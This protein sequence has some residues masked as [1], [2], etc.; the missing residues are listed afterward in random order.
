[1][2]S[3]YVGVRGIS[4][5]CTILQRGQGESTVTTPKLSIRLP[6]GQLTAPV[7]TQCTDR[8]G[9][10]CS[11][12]DRFVLERQLSSPSDPLGLTAQASA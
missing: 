8:V 5:L 11:C 9:L 4:L 3:G 7:S 6:K 1:M 12:I 2:A 10:Y